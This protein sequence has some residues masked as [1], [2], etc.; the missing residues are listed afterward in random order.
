[1]VLLMQ[2]EQ[3]FQMTRNGSGNNVTISGVGHPVELATNDYFELTVS[4]D[5]N[6]V[7]IDN[8]G[9]GN[10]EVYFNAFSLTI[11]PGSNI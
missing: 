2:T 6:N 7:D 11:I 5:D 8:S 1:M 10:N 4:T 3:L 9:N